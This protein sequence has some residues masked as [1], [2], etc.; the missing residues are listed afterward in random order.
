MLYY[1]PEEPQVILV[2]FKLVSCV[3]CFLQGDRFGGALDGAAKMFSEAYDSGTIPMEFVN[4]MRKQGK[5]ILGIGHRIKSVSRLFHLKANVWQL[6][7]ADLLSCQ[8][9]LHS[10]MRCED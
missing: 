4:N 1:A 5:L 3:N 2:L 10:F 7:L 8:N 9:R 6:S